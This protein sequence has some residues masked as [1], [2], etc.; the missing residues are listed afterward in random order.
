MFLVPI[1]AL[2]LAPL[3]VGGCSERKGGAQS[4]PAPANVTNGQARDD[5]P[6]ADLLDRRLIGEWEHTFAEGEPCPAGA[7]FPPGTRVVLEFHADGTLTAT[8]HSLDQKKI[9]VK[10][11]WRVVDTFPDD[12]SRFS[13]QRQDVEGPAGAFSPGATVFDVIN[14]LDDDLVTI[15]APADVKPFE[16]RR[17]R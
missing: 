4:V 6:D 14:F 3:S 10:R 15:Q 16:Y 11:T 5:K 12:E 1:A 2:S 8:T 17:K 13:I 7:L 9:E